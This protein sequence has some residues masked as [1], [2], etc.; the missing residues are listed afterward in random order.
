[1]DGEVGVVVALDDMANDFGEVGGGVVGVGGPSEGE[2]AEGVLASRGF[3]V[4]GNG[5]VEGVE[6]H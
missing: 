4:K 5:V 1:V 2:E 3:W 6:E